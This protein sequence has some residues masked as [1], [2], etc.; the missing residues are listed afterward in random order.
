MVTETHKI[1]YED[2]LVTPCRINEHKIYPDVSLF[3]TSHGKYSGL[4]IS[5]TTE[6]FKKASL[7]FENSSH[8]MTNLQIN[9]FVRKSDISHLHMHLSPFSTTR[10]K[11][12]FKRIGNIITIPTT[13]PIDIE[14]YDRE[15][16]D[17]FLGNS[18]QLVLKQILALICDIFYKKHWPLTKID[19]HHVKDIE[20]ED[21]EYI[22]IVFTFHVSFEK[23][24]EYLHSFYNSLDDLA[25][26]FN[27]TEK[28][29]LQRMIY[30]DIQTTL[31]GD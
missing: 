16:I 14:Y 26:G 5:S 4:E 1:T 8:K 24:D 17:S 30:F 25:S 31:S 19:V 28:G 21:W 23:A 29:I 13:M 9:H 22:L 15:Y 20:V 12:E 10:N 18:G 27:E 7:F 11:T 6:Y 2:K 3:F